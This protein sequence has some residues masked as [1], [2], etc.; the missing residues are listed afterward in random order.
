MLIS[1]GNKKIEGIVVENGEY[2]H[3]VI[4]AK[5]LEIPMVIN[6][7]GFD[8]IVDGQPLIIDGGKGKIIQTLQK[9]R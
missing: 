5:A 4:I 7:S 9:N 6:V 3:S 2:S 8:E 1:L